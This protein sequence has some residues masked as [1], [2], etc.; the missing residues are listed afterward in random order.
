MKLRQTIKKIVALAAG[1][2]ILGTTLMAASAANLANYPSPFVKNGVFDGLIVVGEK[3]ATA[4]VIGAVDIAAGLQA[5]AYSMTDVSCEGGIT[6]SGGKTDEIPLGANVTKVGTTS[7]LDATLRDD[8][9]SGLQ[10][11]NIDL[12][13]SDYDTHDEIQLTGDVKIL[14]SLSAPDDKYGSDVYME[15]Q[16]AGAIQYCYKFDETV[17]LDVHTGSS[18][19]LTIDFLGQTL[20]IQDI[21]S[22]TSIQAVAGTEMFFDAGDTLEVSGKTVTFVKAGTSSAVVDVDGEQEVISSGTTETVNGIKVRVKEV[23]N[24]D[25]TEFDSAVMIVG[26]DA[27]ETYQTGDAYIG[28]DKNTPDWVWNLAGLTTAGTAQTLCVKNKKVWNDLS[29][30]PVGVGEYY[31]MPND[32]IMIGIDSLTVADDNYATYKVYYESSADLSGAG[33]GT[34]E[35][36]FVIESVDFSEGIKILATPGSGAWLGTG[37]NL[38]ADIRTDKVYIHVNSYNGNIV[39]IMYEDTNNKIADAG[40]LLMNVTTQDINF[41]EI[42]F[43]DTKGTDIGIDLRGL[44]NASTDNITLGFDIG[45]TNL[46]DGT[47]DIIVL[48]GDDHSGDF[49]ALGAS[50][51]IDEDN[52]LVYYTE[53]TSIGT[54]NE[55][56]RTKYGIIIRDPEDH[57]NNDEVEMEIPG[58]QVKANVVVKTTGA[59]VASTSGTSQSVNPIAVGMGVLDKDATVGDEN[60]IVVG[61]PCANTIAA[62]L[63]GNPDPCGEGFEMGKAKLKAFD[64]GS[65]VSILVAGYEAMETQGACRVLADYEDYALSGDDMEVTVTSLT[66]LE[67]AAV[68]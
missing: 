5:E 46:N 28:Q 23:F 60:L 18:T 17:N 2:T 68:E 36:A 52:E 58:D 54:K 41:A 32:F 6:V 16:A 27:L 43:K 22:A 31:S 12:N 59:S 53:A 10:D 61:G 55:D 65:K 62:E 38:T 63:L 34:G 3:A 15:V 66:D 8:D 30:D 47:D 64:S 42:N 56:H 7:L 37:G 1:T 24:E 40:T 19:P 57:G 48:L 67:V 11:T 44:L 14:T 39:D 20:E 9:V 26:L 4:D 13:G 45:V 35:K 29:D 25:G 49:D 33:S 50:L 21:A 51:S